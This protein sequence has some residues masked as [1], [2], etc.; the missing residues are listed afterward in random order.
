MSEAAAAGAFGGPRRRLTHPR[1]AGLDPLGALRAAGNPGPL[2]RTP[3]VLLHSGRVDAESARF[4]VLGR[5]AW[6]VA[7]GAGRLLPLGPAPV[8]AEPAPD[9]FAALEAV[10]GDGA[11]WLGYLAYDLGRA[12]EWLPDSA[13]DDRGWPGFGWWRCPGWLEHD[14][15]GGGWFACGELAGRG[16]EEVLAGL[17]P[18]LDAPPAPGSA[19]GF[20]AGAAEPDRPEA[21]HLAAVRA[22]LGYVA[23]GDAFQVNVARRWGGSFS[24]DPAALYA[25]LAAAAEPWYGAHLPCPGLPGLAGAALCSASPELFLRV[26]PDGVVTTR[27]IKGT[28]PAGGG[29][30]EASGKDAAELAM[31]VDLLRNDL[32]RVCRPGTVSVPEGRS[33]EEHPTVRHGVAT[34]RGRLRADAGLA[35]L[36]R[37]TWPGGSVTGAPK[38]RAMEIIEELEPVRRGPYCGSIGGIRRA[39]GASEGA[40]GGWRVALNLAI[41]TVC[42]ADGRFDFHVGGGVV[43]DSSPEAELAETHVKA[44]A[45]LRALGAGRAG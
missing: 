35:G 5:P 16:D 12:V 33:V 21:E 38:V 37:A 25:A 24:G 8:E 29:S 11:L 28:E 31:I 39:G 43:A 14:A 44:A 10:T 13:A 27:P 26:G 15:V 7:W 3:A 32:G 2:P 4:S 9:P 42:V 20:V 40:S 36:L 30:L 6:G 18:G 34:V 23:A 19:P 41:R 45:M 22:C 1:V 17:L